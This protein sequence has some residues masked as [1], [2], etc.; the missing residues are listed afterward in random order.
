MYVQDTF[1]AIMFTIFKKIAHIFFFLFLIYN[2]LI[3]LKYQMKK[4]P[5]ISILKY[6]RWVLTA[7]HCAKLVFIG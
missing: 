6:F 2:I 1:I 4:Q 5:L 7:A 3:R